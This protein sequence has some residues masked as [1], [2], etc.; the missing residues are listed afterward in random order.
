M[1]PAH[2]G[3][4]ASMSGAAIRNFLKSKGADVSATSVQLMSKRR[5]LIVT[6]TKSG[7][8]SDL[9]PKLLERRTDRQAAADMCEFTPLLEGAYSVLFKGPVAI[10]GYVHP[11]RVVDLPA[12]ECTCG[13]WQDQMFPFVHAVCAASKDG[14]RI[15]DLYD[16]KR[17][18]IEH[19]RDTYTF[20]FL[21]W[22]TTATLQRDD[23]ILPPQLEPTHERIG[24]RGLKPGKR[25]QHKRKIVKNAL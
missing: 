23:T 3:S 18:S 14:R 1:L 4:T 25:P 12:L 20:K 8:L 22:P 17:M 13:N 7:A 24:N 6:W 15:E 19:F 10:P 16:A 11:D 2:D 5:Q 9:V 21:P